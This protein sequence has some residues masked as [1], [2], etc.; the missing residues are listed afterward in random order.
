MTAAIVWN[1]KKLGRRPMRSESMP[2]KGPQNIC[3][4][5]QT[6][7]KTTVTT[8]YLGMNCQMWPFTDVRV[9]RALS[10]AIDRRK[11]HLE[12]PIKAL[13][14]FKVTLKLHKDVS[15][16]IPVHVVRED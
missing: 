13:G 10:Y 9:R 5:P 3:M 16:D 8:R 1:R 2:S 4:I 6:L 15:V 11:V 7:A 14:D 12:E